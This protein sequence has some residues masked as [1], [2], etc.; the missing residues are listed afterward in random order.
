MCGIVD[1]FRHGNVRGHVARR[2]ERLPVAVAERDV[3]VGGPFELDDVGGVVDDD[4]E[5]DLQ[6]EPVRLRDEVGEVLVG[7]EVR[8]DGREV[9][10]PVAVVGG[11]AVLERVVLQHGRDPER[12]EAEVLD[13]LEVRAQARQVA[14]VVVGRVGRVEARLRPRAAQ[15]ARGRSPP[16][17][18]A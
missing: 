6:P 14:A 8:V 10:P 4:V 7:A 9:E 2:V 12:G 5:V 11:A 1:A 3:G 15:A 13:A 18:F 17:P 16:K